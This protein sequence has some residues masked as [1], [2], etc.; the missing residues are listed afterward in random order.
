MIMRKLHTIVLILI[1]GSLAISG[2]AQKLP[3]PMSPP[4]MV[5]DFAAFLNENDALSL[6]KKLR[7]FYG[8]SSTQIYIVTVS[9]L[10][11]YDPADFATQLGEKWGIGTRGKD[12][13]MLILIKPKTSASKGEVFISVGYGLE[14]VV[15]DAIANR[16]VD[17]EV[18]PSFRNGN[19]YQGL[20][21]ATNVLI[22]LTQ[23]EYTADQYQASNP[24]TKGGSIYGIIFFIIFMAILFGGRNRMGRHS[25]LGRNLPLWM[26][27]GMMGS[28]SRSQSGM[29][30]NFSGG[31][32]GF[33][34]FGGGGGGSF[35]G[36][37]AGGSW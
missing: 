34:G 10:L 13:G 24:E 2:Y 12:N 18:L 22:E 30:G 1:L 26:L 15:P 36:G 33:G 7:D 8:S 25:S 31:S 16:I 11:G 17:L 9:D 20:D 5:N 19:Y 29:F 23:G 6:E 32:G 21:K 27:L 4:R 28:G 14:G 3:E 37:G 35:G